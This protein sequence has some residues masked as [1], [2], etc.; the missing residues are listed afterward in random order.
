MKELALFAGAGGG[1]LGE[2]E[3]HVLATAHNR[4]NAL[5]VGDLYIR[6]I[7]DGM[8]IHRFV[9]NKPLCPY[10]GGQLTVSINGWHKE[11]DGWVAD[12]LQLDCENADEKHEDRCDMPYLKLL[13]VEQQILRWM[14]ASYRWKLDDY[15]LAQATA[16]A[17]P[18]QH[19]K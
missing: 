12:D 19:P 8:P 5:I 13:L 14:N 3:G 15:D 7:Q 11:D 18:K 9:M 1:I 16:G 17:E 2:C 4:F 6:V 10:C